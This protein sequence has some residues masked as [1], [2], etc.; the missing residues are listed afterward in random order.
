MEKL[1]Q[2]VR[3]AMWAG[4]ETP[5]ALVAHFGSEHTVEELFLAWHA[6]KILERAEEENAR[7]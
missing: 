1:I 5:E 3:A 2:R 4:V 6:A 7:A